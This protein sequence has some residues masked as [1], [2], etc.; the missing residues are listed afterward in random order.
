MTKRRIMTFPSQKATRF[1]QPLKDDKMESRSS[2]SEKP[3]VNLPLPLD[4][5]RI[6]TERPKLISRERANSFKAPPPRTAF[7]IKVGFRCPD[8]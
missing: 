2:L 8:L 1:D 3:K 5:A 4:P 6:R 7:R